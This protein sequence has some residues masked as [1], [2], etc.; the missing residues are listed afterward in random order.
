MEKS[1][2]CS[3]LNELVKSDNSSE[4][5]T[6]LAECL[7]QNPD[8]SLDLSEP[9]PLKIET[10]WTIVTET[11]KEVVEFNSEVCL[12]SEWEIPDFPDW[13]SQRFLWENIDLW[14][15]N[16]NHWT[17]Q[18]EIP[19]ALPKQEPSQDQVQIT[20]S[21]VWETNAEI[22][23]QTQIIPSEPI[24]TQVTESLDSQQNWNNQEIAS[25]EASVQEVASQANEI[26]KTIYEVK[27]WDNLW[28]IVKNHYNL[29][30]NVDILNKVKEVISKQEDGKLKNKLIKHNWNLIHT[31]DK[32]ILD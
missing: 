4:N 6:K 15:T 20:E 5:I 22:A 14:L 13:S 8:S 1:N 23:S 31:W 11:R 9:A 2:P 17:D 7:I 21:P 32:L 12:A 27:S 18:V 29:S 28:L 10:V 16:Q 30:W 26:Q 24:V 25:Q 3:D 19:F